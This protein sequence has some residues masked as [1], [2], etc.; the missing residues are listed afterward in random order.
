MVSK[1][2]PAGERSAKEDRRQHLEVREGS[3]P[4]GGLR[5]IISVRDSVSL[6]FREW[7]TTRRNS[8]KRE[9]SLDFKGRRLQETERMNR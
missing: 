4:F 1:E 5:L 3:W 9:K 2:L 6:G 8:S 7:G